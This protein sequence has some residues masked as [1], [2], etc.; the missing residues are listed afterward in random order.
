MIGSRLTS[1]L[2]KDG[3]SDSIA[4]SHELKFKAF[5]ATEA[6]G[7]APL[8]TM[9]SDKL[10]NR[11]GGSM[12]IAAMAA[13]AAREKNAKSAK[14]T[15]PSTTATKDDGAATIDD[16]IDDRSS[17]PTE[18]SPTK[19]ADLPTLTYACVTCGERLVK[20]HFSKNQLSKSKKNE[21]MRCKKCTQA[22]R[23]AQL[24]PNQLNEESFVLI[25]DRTS[26][27]TVQ[28]VDEISGSAAPPGDL[29]PNTASDE[30]NSAFERLAL[31]DDDGCFDM[32]SVPVVDIVP[33][34]AAMIDVAIEVPSPSAVRYSADEANKGVHGRLSKENQMTIHTALSPSTHFCS[35]CGKRL[36]KSQ[37][38]KN[39]LAKA[40]KNEIVRCKQCIAVQRP[41]QLELHPRKQRMDEI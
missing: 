30:E 18:K 4:A 22:Q 12:S 21:F 6:S 34:D 9:R 25:N 31:I 27:K 10:R 17:I 41:A 33:T 20:S 36:E 35:A 28:K 15:S 2:Q 39:Q 19:H 38:S 1:Q 8:A 40:K 26:C 16:P 29:N 11:A 24:D 37:F 23:P 3:T 7:I 5:A 14:L 32:R 13:A